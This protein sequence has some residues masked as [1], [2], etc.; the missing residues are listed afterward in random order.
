[1]DGA[2]GPGPS[3]VLKEEAVEYSPRQASRRSWKAAE[4][5]IMGD[6]TLPLPLLFNKECINIRY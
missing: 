6:I 3:L 5:R 2:T 1:M 4:V